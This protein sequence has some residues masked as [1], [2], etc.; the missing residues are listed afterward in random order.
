[1]TAILKVLTKNGEIHEFEFETEE[2]A[3]RWAVAIKLAK[4]EFEEDVAC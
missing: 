3:Y 4:E 2:E 1:M